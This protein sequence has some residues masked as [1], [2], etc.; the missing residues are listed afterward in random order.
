MILPRKQLQKQ[1]VLH[2]KNNP[3]KFFYRGDNYYR[4]GPIGRPIDHQDGLPL[5][6]EGNLCQYERHDERDV[7]RAM[8]NQ[9]RAKDVESHLTPG[10]KGGID[11][12]ARYT[13]F[14]SVRKGIVGLYARDKKVIKVKTSLLLELQAA[15]KIK[16]LWPADVAELILQHYPSTKKKVL[17]LARNLKHGMIARQEVLIEGEIPTQYVKL[18]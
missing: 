18:S 12:S 2:D 16:I 10:R 3:P 9:H 8:V 1:K 5:D 17:V 14:K 15:G 11:K 4:G 6:E 7:A 13:S